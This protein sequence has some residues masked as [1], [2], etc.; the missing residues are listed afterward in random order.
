MFEWIRRK[1][2]KRPRGDVAEEDA[3]RR[4]AES[5]RRKAEARAAEQEQRHGS[6]GIPGRG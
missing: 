3:L 5:E 2:P 1:L 6:G 4:R